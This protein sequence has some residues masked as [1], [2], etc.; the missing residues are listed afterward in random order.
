MQ[1]KAREVALNNR[2]QQCSKEPLYWKTMQVLFSIK[3]DSEIKAV[4]ENHKTSFDQVFKDFVLKILS[5]F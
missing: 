3:K 5:V 1:E 4:L 2:V